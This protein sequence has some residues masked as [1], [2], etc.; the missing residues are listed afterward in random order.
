MRLLKIV[1]AWAAFLALVAVIG[2][3][4][5]D[6][7]HCRY[8]QDCRGYKHASQ[9]YEENKHNETLW[10]RTTND[11]IAFYTLLL[12]VFT[13]GLTFASIWQGY[14]L[15]RADKTARTAA[16]AAL[17]T[18]QTAIAQATHMERYAAE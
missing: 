3:A 9:R 16:D 8:T 2:S 6:A 10:E 12:A 5:I 18:A 17:T 4:I 11:P 14:F 1:V 13:G 15:V 7:E